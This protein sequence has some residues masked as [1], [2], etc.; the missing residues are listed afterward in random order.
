MHD[1]MT[2]IYRCSNVFTLWHVD[3]GKGGSDDSCGWFMR[4]NHG[5]EEVFKKIQKRFDYEW[6]NDKQLPAWF[7]PEGYPLMSIHAIVLCMFSIVAYEANYG[8][9]GKAERFMK[10]N[11]YDI[12]HLAENPRDSMRESIVQKYGPEPRERRVQNSASI[13]YGC[14]LR[15]SRPWY[16]HPRWHFWH[17]KITL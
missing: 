7:S 16:K 13:V 10:N 12:I 1:P 11:L 5:D 6:S 2:M 9:W 8:N 15:W 17:W 14:Y 4:S 3:P